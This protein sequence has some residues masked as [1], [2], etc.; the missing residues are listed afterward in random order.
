MP[1]S[2]NQRKYAEVKYF[3]IIIH[4]ASIF[5][6]YNGK[7]ALQDGKREQMAGSHS[8]TFWG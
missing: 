7:V 1:K 4:A 2:L 5:T 8:P 3:A 6:M